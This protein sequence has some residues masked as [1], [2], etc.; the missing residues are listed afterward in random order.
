MGGLGEGAG[1]RAPRLRAHE[2]QGLIS[3][4]RR[5]NGYRAYSNEALMTLD[6]ITSAQD[7]GFT[8]GEIRRLVPANVSHGR[9]GALLG[10]LRKK[11]DDIRA[12]EKRLAQTRLQIVAL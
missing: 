9:S 1:L 4:A 7:A 5:A 2:A 12:M 10:A 6:I 11:I 8:L 3:A